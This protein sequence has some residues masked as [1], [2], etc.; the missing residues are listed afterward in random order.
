MNFLQKEAWNCSHNLWEQFIPIF[1]LFI[2]QKKILKIFERQNLN[3]NVK[4]A[5]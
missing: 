2:F 3:N 4:Q 1:E 5:Q